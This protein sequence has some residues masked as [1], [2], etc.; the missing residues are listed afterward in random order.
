M[1][2]RTGRFYLFIGVININIYYKINYKV[3]GDF[4][5]WLTYCMY[6][7][8]R[9]YIILYVRATKLILLYDN[10]V[11]CLEHDIPIHKV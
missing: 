2:Q 5:M 3:K 4:I 7:S 11:L 8:V 10:D 9:T 6:L 1:Q